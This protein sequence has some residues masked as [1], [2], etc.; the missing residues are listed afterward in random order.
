MDRLEG[1]DKTVLTPIAAV[2]SE[3]PVKPLTESFNPFK[4]LKRSGKSALG[5]LLINPLW[6]PIFYMMGMQI[7]EEKKLVLLNKAICEIEQRLSS[8]TSTTTSILL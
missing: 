3:H 4:N 2:F 7:N 8:N 6:M 1:H 5:G